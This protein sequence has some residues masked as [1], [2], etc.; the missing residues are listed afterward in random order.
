MAGRR[1][2]R[3]DDAKRATPAQRWATPTPV[4]HATT[5]NGYRFAKWQG[6][7]NFRK[8]RKLL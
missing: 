4:R 6:K 5:R 2:R 8:M 7:P 1:H 3:A